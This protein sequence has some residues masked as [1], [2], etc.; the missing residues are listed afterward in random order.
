MVRFGYKLMTEEQ[1]PHELV[2]NAQRA[3]ALG[4]DFVA[5][6]DHFFPWLDS[7]GHSPFAWSV[8]GA[9]A[10]ATERVDITTAVT[11]PILRYH[12]AIVAQAAATMGV[13][14]NGRFSLG[15]GTGELLN[16][17]VV[18]R[19]WPS[20]GVRQA[21]LA[22]AIEI[23][24]MLFD[25]EMHSYRGEFLELEEAR[26]YDRPEVPPPILVAAGGDQAATLAAERADGLFTAE[27]ESR[28]VDAYREAGGEG[29]RYCEIA[30]ACADSEK[31]AHRL[32]REYYRWSAFDWHVLPELPTPAAFDAA[33]GHVRGEDLAEATPAGPD[34]ERHLEAIREGVEAGYDHVVLN[35]I[36]PDQETFFRFFEKELSPRLREWRGGET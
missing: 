1:G 16:E 22:E 25:G 18:G 27:S 10:T 34:P 26:L 11:C 13:L 5:I 15:L 8:L 17:H 2:R 24:R 36:G 7:E 21:M 6:S 9:V 19:R 4:L 23:I 3:E 32:L 31:E 14:S 35:P 29:P 33:S 12:P 30:L 20:V 28:L